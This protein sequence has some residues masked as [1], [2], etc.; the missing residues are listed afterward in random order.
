MNE[1]IFNFLSSLSGVNL[2]NGTFKFHSRDAKQIFWIIKESDGISAWITDVGDT[3]VDGSQISHPKYAKSTIGLS[4]E[5]IRDLQRLEIDDRATG[6]ARADAQSKIDKSYADALALATSVHDRKVAYDTWF[7]DS[8]KVKDIE[9]YKPSGEWYRVRG[10]NVFHVGCALRWSACQPTELPYKILDCHYNNGTFMFV[11]FTNDI[12]NITKSLVIGDVDTVDS[13]IHGKSFML[14]NSYVLSSD[15]KRAGYGDAFYLESVVKVQ[16]SIQAPVPNAEFR[17][18]CESEI[19]S[20]FRVDVDAEPD[21]KEFSVNGVPVYLYNRIADVNI[22]LFDDTKKDYPVGSITDPKLIKYTYKKLHHVLED[23]DTGVGVNYRPLM[24]TKRVSEEK[25]DFKAKDYKTMQVPD[26]SGTGGNS[27]NSKNNVSEIMP[28]IFYI[29]RDPDVRDDWSMIGHTDVI[30]Y[31]N[32]YNI[33][34]GR[35]LQS[36]EYKRIAKHACYNLY[37]RRAQAT[38][39]NKIDNDDD[40]DFTDV[41]GLGGYPGLAFKV[42]V[43]DNLEVIRDRVIQ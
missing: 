20:L 6:K 22:P 37:R 15:T 24:N 10:N 33:G 25:Y 43:N 38:Y 13:S 23:V 4:G 39:Y 5:Y 9:M 21:V 28:F 26:Y 19:F 42:S 3:E 40:N 35:L 41:R 32:M 17:V 2:S 7:A 14:S 36:N 1:K 16:D 8:Q 29:L 18:D 27:V 11:L 12:P 30:N 34:T 31:I